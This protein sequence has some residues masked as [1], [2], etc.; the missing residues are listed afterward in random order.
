MALTSQELRVL[1]RQITGRRLALEQEIRVEIARSRNPTYGKV[2]GLAPDLGDGALADLIVDLD[3]AEVAR[4]LAELRELEAA[5]G[6]MDDGS[7]GECVDC[8]LDIGLARL[9]ALPTALRCIDCQSVRE[10]VLV[11][12]D[13][14]QL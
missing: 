11:Q 14:P 12:S 9:H 3:N 10:K 5:L 1:E 7:Y 8:G 2:A 6:R 4:D 13:R